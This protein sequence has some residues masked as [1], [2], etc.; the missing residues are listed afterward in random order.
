MTERFAPFEQRCREAGYCHICGVDEAGRGPL[1]GDVFAAA[2]LLPAA[3]DLP[4]LNDSK[5]LAPKRREALFAQIQSQA[6]A[7]AVSSASVE[8]IEALNI[9]QASL[10]AMR[11]AVAALHAPCDFALVDGNR[12]PALEIPG[13]AIIKGDSLCASIAAASILAKV[14]RDRAMAFHDAQYPGYGFAQHKGYGTKAHYE[15]LA[16]LGPCP[17]HRKSF[18]HMEF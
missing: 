10:L 6:V 14:S 5:R 7:W 11:R 2:V 3:Y 9:L 18:I 8:E 1:A 4:G 16:T 17:I 12:L 15:A 13:Q